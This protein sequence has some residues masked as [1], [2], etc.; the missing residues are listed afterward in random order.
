MKFDA[1]DSK[2]VGILDAYVPTRLPTPWKL[3]FL[4]KN[5]YFQD[6]FGKNV[7]QH[8]SATVWIGNFEKIWK[9]GLR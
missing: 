4:D 2:T 7:K 9:I 5:Q 1:P 8:D 6:P 3:G